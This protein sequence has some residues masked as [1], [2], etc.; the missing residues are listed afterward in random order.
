MIRKILLFIVIAT[1]AITTFGYPSSEEKLRL[2]LFG[3]NGKSFKLL[4]I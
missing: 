2:G 3:N 4:K 1:I